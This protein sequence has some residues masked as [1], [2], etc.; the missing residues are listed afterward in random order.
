MFDR[1][2]SV[3]VEHMSHVNKVNYYSEMPCLKIAHITPE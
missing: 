1:N 2:F 3:R